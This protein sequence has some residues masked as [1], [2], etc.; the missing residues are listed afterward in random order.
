MTTQTSSLTS[1]WGTPGNFVPSQLLS[2]PRH[3]DNGP[4]CTVIPTPVLFTVDMPPPDS[5][6]SLWSLPLRICVWGDYLSFSLWPDMW[7]WPWH[8][9]LLPPPLANGPWV[10]R[11]LCVRE[12][13]R[14][15]NC[16]R[17]QKQEEKP[18]KPWN[19]DGFA[20]SNPSAFPKTNYV[21]GLHETTL[22]LQQIPPLSP[23]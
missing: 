19:S 22:Q 8:H 9:G 7:P 2:S 15:I 18:Q 6:G 12:T 11:T 4:L 10:R 3:H 16:G 13:E 5:A 20:I 1:L 14:G 17:T 21:L 23:H